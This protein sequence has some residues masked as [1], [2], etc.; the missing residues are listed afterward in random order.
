MALSYLCRRHI[1][2]V[3]ITLSILILRRPV[4]LILSKSKPHQHRAG[5]SSVYQKYS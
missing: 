4:G 3:I 2:I 1:V 5:K